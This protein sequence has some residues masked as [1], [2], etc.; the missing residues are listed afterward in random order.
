M[1]GFGVDLIQI[2]MRQKALR[3]VEC[4][5]APVG[6]AQVEQFRRFGSDILINDDNI[7]VCRIATN[8]QAK[9]NDLNGR[10][11]KFKQQQAV[12]AAQPLDILPDQ[13]TQ[14]MTVGHPTRPRLQ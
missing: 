7:E 12:V 1:E 6:I 2:G 8:G 5:L 3:M 11:D 10:K 13:R 9:D 4:L 14:A